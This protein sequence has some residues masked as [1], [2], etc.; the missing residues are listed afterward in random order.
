[1]FKYES[2]SKKKFA[3]YLL[4]QKLYSIS[5]FFDDAQPE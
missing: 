1:M 3:H 5:L 4:H 2:Q